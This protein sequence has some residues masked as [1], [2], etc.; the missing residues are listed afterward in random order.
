MPVALDTTAAALIAPG[1][2][3]HG[4]VLARFAAGDPYA[5]TASVVLELTYGY[6]KKGRQDTGWN[7][8]R[9][10]LQSLLDGRI[11]TTLPFDARA[12]AVVGRL[13][14]AHPYAP[15]NTSAKKS[16]R[17]KP[18][19]RVAWVMDL[20]TAASVYVAGAS[21]ASDDVHHHD[22]ATWL[23]GWTNAPAHSVLPA[24]W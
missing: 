9:E 19:T 12:A 23:T 15:K 4:T 6:E 18:D 20:Q 7:T 16:A 8:Q 14:A 5:L 13:R 3:A 11:L 2:A 21:L 24:P 10:F 1:S 22:V 17:S